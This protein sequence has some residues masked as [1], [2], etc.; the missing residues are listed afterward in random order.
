MSDLGNDIIEQKLQGAW[1]TIINQPWYTQ[2]I[3]IVEEIVK[4]GTLRQ[5]WIIISRFL[6]DQD[7]D[8][9]LKRMI[10]GLIFVCRSL[11]GLENS[12]LAH[13]IDQWWNN[14][15]INPDDVF[16]AINRYEVEGTNEEAPINSLL[17]ML[18]E[19]IRQ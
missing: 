3:T 15:T 18:R 7:V 9:L 10:H 16:S 11:G 8:P 5:D 14:V 2:H 19:K 17:M 13:Q 6:R 12:N 4:I 1:N